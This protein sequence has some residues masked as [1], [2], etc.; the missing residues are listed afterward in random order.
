VG[1]QVRQVKGR[2]EAERGV[3]EGQRRG[4]GGKHEGGEGGR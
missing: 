4:K 3:K 1:R 2:G